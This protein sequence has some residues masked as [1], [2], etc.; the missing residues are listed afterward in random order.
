MCN[1][2]LRLS[3]GMAGL[4]AG[5]GYFGG[6]ATAVAFLGVSAGGPVLALVAVGAAVYVGVTAFR[7]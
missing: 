5:Y 4:F 2:G 7:C 6:A 3:V 1:P